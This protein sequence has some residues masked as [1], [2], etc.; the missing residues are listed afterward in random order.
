MKCSGKHDTTWNI[1]RSITFS[2]F[3]A[4]FHVISRKINFLGT[5]CALEY[6]KFIVKIKNCMNELNSPSCHPQPSPSSCWRWSPTGSY[7]SS[8]SQS[9]SWRRWVY[10]SHKIVQ[11]CTMNTAA[12]SSVLKYIQSCYNSYTCIYKVD[13]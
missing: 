6:Y 3:P 7:S 4:T 11:Y 13:A 2:V 8:S 5:V 12:Y 10:S 9:R 1:P